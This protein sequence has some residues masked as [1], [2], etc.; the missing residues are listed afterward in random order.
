MSATIVTD[1]YPMEDH[2][3]VHLSW[4]RLATNEQLLAAIADAAWLLKADDGDGCPADVLENTRLSQLAVIIAAQ[5]EQS[6]RDSQ[7]LERPPMTFG[8]RR[9]IL[10]DIKARVR[11][12]DEIG[13]ALPLHKRGSIYRTNCPFHDD[14]H[15]SLIVWPQSGRWKCYPCNV[16]GDVFTWVQA[17]LPTDFRGAVDYL[18][19][20]AGVTLPAKPHPQRPSKTH[21]PHF[22]YRA[23]RIVVS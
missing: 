7:G 4:A 1:T 6:Y 20:R 16:G 15:P 5:R 11:L 13:L 18:S 22:E 12:E 3:R 23:G 9:E 2:I 17:W 10:D 19:A 14:N 8:I 21:S